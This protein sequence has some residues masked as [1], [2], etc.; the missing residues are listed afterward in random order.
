M[1]I[2]RERRRKVRSDFQMNNLGQKPL[3]ECM[4]DDVAVVAVGVDLRE[5]ERG[6]RKY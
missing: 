4:C 3:S 6:A 1:P 2:K 5:R